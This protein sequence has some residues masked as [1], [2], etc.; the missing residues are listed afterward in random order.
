MDVEDEKMKKN[1]VLMEL[2]VK[3]SYFYDH[4]CEALNDHRHHHHH[5]SAC[6]HCQRL[7][8]MLEMKTKMKTKMKKK[9]QM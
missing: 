5:S 9:R 7:E 6:H 8:Q 3:Q 4:R 2:Q 1:E